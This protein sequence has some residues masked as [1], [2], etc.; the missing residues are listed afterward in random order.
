MMNAYEWINS[1]DIAQHLDKIKYDFT[2]LEYA[3]LIWQKKGAS[4]FKRH[5]AWHDIITYMQ[6]EDF[7]ANGYTYSMHEY[8]NRLIKAQSK[9][10]HDFY[11]EQPETYYNGEVVTYS[12]DCWDPTAFAT[13]EAC[14]K[15]LDEY[16]SFSEEVLYNQI[17]K[18]RKIGDEYEVEYEAIFDNKLQI[19][20]INTRYF[21]NIF[22]NIYLNFP[23]PFKKG[24][25]LKRPQ[26]LI[27]TLDTSRSWEEKVVFEDCGL[28]HENKNS[29]IED[30]TLTGYYM[31]FNRLSRDTEA[32][33]MDFEFV[34]ENLVEAERLLIL[35][36]A[37]MNNKMN[38][39]EFAEAYHIIKNEFESDD[40]PLKQ[41]IDSL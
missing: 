2:G 4:L 20:D 10:E 34:H 6:D 8:L 38:L 41:L 21:K 13:F 17:T 29:G 23:V 18:Y 19:Q 14:K 22:K 9:A 12:S 26:H 33:Y 25:I 27:P 28:P 5:Y 36:Q 15:H 40:K 16:V 30:M 24:D 39:I 11:L 37:Y 3:W 35:T 7:E 32:C 1:K 31:R